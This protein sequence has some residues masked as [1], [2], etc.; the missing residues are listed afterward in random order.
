MPNITQEQAETVLNVLMNSTPNLP[1]Y[2]SIAAA[3]IMQ[4]IVQG[5]P[6]PEAPEE[7]RVTLPSK[8]KKRGK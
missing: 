5:V 8:R 7:K 2:Q 1:L 4:S 3:G 6:T